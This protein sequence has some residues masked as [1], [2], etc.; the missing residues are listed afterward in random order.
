[1][2]APPSALAT[3]SRTGLANHDD[4]ILTGHT[5]ASAIRVLQWNVNRASGD[6]RLRQIEALTGGGV[7]LVVLTEVAAGS[8]AEEYLGAL[9]AAGLTGCASSRDGVPGPP[10]ADGRRRFG[11]VL[12]SRWQLSSVAPI[13]GAPWPERTLDVVVA[14]PVRDIRVLA[15]YA[16]LGRHDTAKSE[17][18]EAA[19][20]AIEQTAGPL[21][22][23]GD[24]NAPRWE[25]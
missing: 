18:F 20:S 23:T 15:I 21:I 16:P 17:T 14:Y 24:F 6:R 1:M 25:G 4:V 5:H 10:A 9:S 19:G 13:T 12:A 8:A 11:V 3:P 2:A 7:D 22:V